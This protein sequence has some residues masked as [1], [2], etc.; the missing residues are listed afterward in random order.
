MGRREQR[1]GIDA[2]G[3]ICLLEADADDNDKEIAGIRLEMKAMNKVL[4]GILASTATAAILLAVN[5]LVQTA[6]K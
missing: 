4:L 2:H 1:E 5:I 3:R 6:G